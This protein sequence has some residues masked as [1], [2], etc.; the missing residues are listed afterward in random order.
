MEPHAMESHAAEIDAGQTAVAQGQFAHPPV[1]LPAAAK[2]RRSRVA[3]W[4]LLVD[5]SMLALATI[6]LLAGDA[7]LGLPQEASPWALAYPVVALAGLALVGLYRVQL[8]TRYLDDLPRI[9]AATAVAA[10]AV[11]FVQVLVVEAPDAATEM[12]R[13]WVLATLLILVGRGGMSVAERRARIHGT[14]GS[15]TLIVGAGRVGRLI[16]RRLIEKPEVGLR[17][18][19]FVDDDPLPVVDLDP[20]DRLEET[21]L[22]IFDTGPDLG[23]VARE[24]RIEHAII[25]FTSSSHETQLDLARR[26]HDLGVTVSV[27]PRLFEAMP[28]R[29]LPQRTVGLPLVS[30]FPSTPGG[31]RM[32]VKYTLDRLLALLA[33]LLL[34]P[35]LIACSLLVVIS[36]GRPVLYRQQRI[37]VGGRDFEM[38]K[39]RTMRTAANDPVAV[40]PAEEGAAVETAFRSGLAPGGVEGEDRRTKA[41]ALLRRLGLDELP[42]L[43]NVA[44]GEMSIVGPRPEREELVPWFERE[45]YRYRERH[46]MKPGITGWA[47]VHGL[48][49]KTSLADRVEWD[50]YYIENWS[51]WLDLKI[52]LLTMT[53]PFQRGVE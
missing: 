17:P 25:G 52:L 10:M 37:G 20:A 46:R 43:F 47:Q 34:S 26:L 11:T 48:R 6:A 32:T 8:G 21:E 13:A 22:P 5:A 18:L 30:I 51:P 3:E 41:G 14:A 15:P 16:A 44:R 24:M 35:I 28:D 29:V 45:V 2:R 50:N 1:A 38:L 27:V 23:A 39:F 9:V 7:I 19:A 33:L 4:D 40:E 12:V 36:A 53:A 42:Q 49:G 31:W